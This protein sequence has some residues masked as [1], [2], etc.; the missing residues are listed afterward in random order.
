MKKTIIIGC[1]LLITNIL[2]GMLLSKYA[3]FN[4][5]L[6]STVIIITTV[7]IAL[8]DKINLSTAYK[9]SMSFVFGF[10]GI[11]EYMCGFFSKST[12]TDNWVIIID[13]ILLV[14]Q[15]LILIV[16]NTVSSKVNNK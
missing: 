11:V 4:M 5:C 14:I 10:L 3:L 6:N 9:I 12:I 1:C 2:T 15:V 16:A 8:L 7:L 13:L